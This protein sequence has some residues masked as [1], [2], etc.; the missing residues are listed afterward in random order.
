MSLELV[1]FLELKFELK[2]N[3]R[4]IQNFIMKKTLNMNSR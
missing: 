3:K 1:K 4:I 2:A